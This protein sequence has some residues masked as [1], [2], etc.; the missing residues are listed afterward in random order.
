MINLESWVFSV[1]SN[2][3]VSTDKELIDYFMSEGK[4]SRQQALYYIDMRS[5]F[6]KEVV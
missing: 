3:E 5:T 1:L 2:D 6:L 4:L